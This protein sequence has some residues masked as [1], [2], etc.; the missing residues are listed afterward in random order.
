MIYFISDF[1]WNHA[2]II[3]YSS[4]PYNDVEEMN[5]TLIKNW[6][7]TVS[8][9]DTIWHLGDFCYLK[10][11]KQLYDLLNSLNGKKN[12][13]LGNHD[14]IIEKNK[15]YLLKS[16]MVESIQ[17]YH[18]FKYNKGFFVLFHYGQRVWNHSHHGSIM[19][20]GHSHGSLPPYGK[21]VDVGI[22]CK[23]ITE[24]YRPVS[25]DEVIN[26]MNKRDI[27]QA[28]RHKVNM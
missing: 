15:D 2:N 5:K 8:P 11:N 6:N 25:I 10:E 19:L 9:N 18:E 4:R 22:D 1:H 14:Q 27:K 7:Q 28:D 3:R 13:I 17:H 23:E 26:Y 20:Y 24:E 12:M 16:R 21:S